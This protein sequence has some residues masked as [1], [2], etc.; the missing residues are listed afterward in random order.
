MH[1]R[2][3]TLLGAFML[4]L[5]VAPAM[6]G[7]LEEG[8]ALYKS[9]DYAQASA[10]LET[11]TQQDPQ[12]A[13]AW[14]Q[15]N[16]AYNKL[17]RYSDALRAA[18]KAG[19]IDGTY[20]FASD[21]AKYTETLQRLERKAGGSSRSSSPNRP[22]GQASNAYDSI[23]QALTAGDVYIAPGASADADR[24]AAVAQRLKPT[25]VKFVVVNS[26]ANSSTLL[27]NGDRIRRYLG[28]TRG[29]VLLASRGGVA[30]ATTQ[31]SRSSARDLALKVAPQMQV[32]DTTGGLEKLAE[33]LVQTHVATAQTRSTA[34]FVLLAAIVGVIVL[35]VATRKSADRKRMKSLRGPLEIQK[36]DVV[37]ALNR[38]DDDLATLPAMRAETVRQ[39]RL[40]AGNCLDQASKLMASAAN[41]MQ[42]ARAKTLL[43][44]ANR[45]IAR[46][47]AAVRA[48]AAAPQGSR[49]TPSP[50]STAATSW[51]TVPETERGV[52]FF[53][54]RPSFLDE[55]TPVTVNLGEGPQ[56]VLACAADMTT[57]KSG[58]VPQVR[59]F[60]RDGRYVPWYA[61]RGYDPYDDYYSR[62]YDNR[63][64]LTDLVTF[65]VIDHMFWDWHR[66]SWGYGYGTPAYAF[67]PDHHVYTDYY[68]ERAASSGDFSDRG[69]SSDGGGADFLGGG[70]GASDGGGA[71]FL[72]SDNS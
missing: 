18:K 14:W 10:K 43:D 1:L 54:S 53:C 31:V 39:A 23:V 30:V 22:S 3:S 11:A 45:E 46:G 67:Y 71:D 4:W 63:S 28:L 2:A 5:A 65:S 24:L 64:L 57:I 37:A 15:L 48:D 36:T 21:P 61:D 27:Q 7:P 8:R 20:S 44:Q 35:V 42:L 19:E 47:Q 12:N 62:G 32:G 6:A 41:S 52:C 16:F 68:S 50:S 69:G 40:D 70:S 66:P 9:G 55:L 51:S 26:R 56:K 34:L 13:K 72:G 49:P 59:A 60:E 29:Y 17:G 58:A 33:S 38:L 25:P